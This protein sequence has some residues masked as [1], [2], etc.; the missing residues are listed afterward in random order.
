MFSWAACSLSLALVVWRAS[1][2]LQVHF[3]KHEKLSGMTKRMENINFLNDY[4]L[5]TVT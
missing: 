1:A 3:H 5:I 4:A 2:V